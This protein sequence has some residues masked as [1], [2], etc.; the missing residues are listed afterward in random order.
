VKFLAD[1]NMDEAI[2]RWLRSLG[3]DVAWMVELGPGTEDQ[4]VL[5]LAERQGRILLTNDLDFGEHV[6]RYGL[7]SQGVILLRVTRESESERLALVQQHWP[8]ISARAEGH[9]VV[10]TDHRMRIRPIG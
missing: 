9:F 3:L 1:E 5:A 7:N 4:E 8:L 10:V 6:F 2:V